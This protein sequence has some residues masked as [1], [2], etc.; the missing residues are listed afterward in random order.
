MEC[1]WRRHKTK[2]LAVLIIMIS[3]CAIASATT[4]VLVKLSNVVQE[5]IVY[6]GAV[7]ELINSP[8]FW[9]DRARITESF[10]QTGDKVDAMI[11]FGTD[12]DS[13][14]RENC[15]HFSSQKFLNLTHPDLVD[16]LNGVYLLKGSHLI[17]DPTIDPISDFEYP[18][19][20]CRFSDE[21]SAKAL[22]EASD[23]KE[24]IEA[25][26]KGKCDSIK[27]ST[28]MPINTSIEDTV[29]RNGYYFYAISALSPSKKGVSIYFS[30]D[31]VTKYYNRSD[32]DLHDCSVSDDECVIPHL[33]LIKSTSNFCLLAYVPIPPTELKTKYN[34]ITTLSTPYGI[35]IVL[36]VTSIILFAITFHVAL[37]ICVCDCLIVGRKR[38][39]C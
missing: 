19:K 25:E 9:H 5:T 31:L 18:T 16:Q 22:T 15:T 7:V 34:F 37:A 20:F 26:K 14:V 6:P 36:G 21:E 23:N 17:F 30:Y 1:L 27:E 38:A 12:C 3:L 10:P 35:I 39:H 13:K 32:F 11:Y 33:T 29:P 28:S 8:Y 2:L 24:L 4:V